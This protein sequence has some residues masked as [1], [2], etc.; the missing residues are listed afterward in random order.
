MFCLTSLKHITQNKTKQNKTKQKPKKTKQT[1][2]QTKQN[3]QT[4]KKKTD[5]TAAR[6]MRTI[7][8]MENPNILL[9][10][11]RNIFNL[12]GIIKTLNGVTQIMY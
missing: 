2:K 11:I 6:L 4:N 8:W 1:N 9:K 12:V 10:K 3:K 5:I 7:K